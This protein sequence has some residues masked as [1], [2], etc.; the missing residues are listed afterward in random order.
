M[1]ERGRG[2]GVGV[3]LLPTL[4]LTPVRNSDLPVAA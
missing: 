4:H 3:F 1:N 2:G